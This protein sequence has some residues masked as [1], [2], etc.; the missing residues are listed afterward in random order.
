MTD[1]RCRACGQFVSYTH[2]HDCPMKDSFIGSRILMKCPECGTGAAIQTIES[3]WCLNPECGLSIA[4]HD[5][6]IEGCF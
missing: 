5:A 4:L 1:L 2:I 3:I 6:T